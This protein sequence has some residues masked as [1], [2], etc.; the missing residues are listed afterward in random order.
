MAPLNEKSQRSAVF[1]EPVAQVGVS[2]GDPGPVV[3]LD[4]DF[5]KGEARTTELPFRERLG[6]SMEGLELFF[7][8]SEMRSWPKVSSG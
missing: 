3:S 1:P 8:K 4:L 7:N 2:K 5:P 6:R